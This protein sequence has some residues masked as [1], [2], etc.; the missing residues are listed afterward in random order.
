[1]TSATGESNE[2]T[3]LE[4]PPNHNRPRNRMGR[5]TLHHLQM[6]YSD[7]LERRASKLA[8]LVALQ[9]PMESIA[10]KLPPY[11]GNVAASEEWLQI[12]DCTHE[13][14]AEVMRC[15]AAG[16]WERKV[17]SGSN[18]KIDYE[19]KIDGVR[20]FIYCA[21]PPSSCRIETEEIE[22]PAHRKTIT[23]LVCK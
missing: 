19:T 5:G 14:A 3:A 4:L 11:L 21:Q 12:S 23:K 6:N 9:S 10:A 15:L 2:L 20:V 17:S 1:M 13:E 8:K 18:S 16:K 7:A 22:V